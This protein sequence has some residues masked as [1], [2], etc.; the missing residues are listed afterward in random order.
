[1]ALMRLCLALVAAPLFVALFLHQ[2][3]GTALVDYDGGETGSRPVVGAKLNLISRKSDPFAPP[4][5]IEVAGPPGLAVG[6]EYPDFTRC[7]LSLVHPLSFLFFL[8]GV[9]FSENR[10]TGR[11]QASQIMRFVTASP[12]SEPPRRTTQG[13]TSNNQ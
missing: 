6:Y 11:L 9:I 1:M 10:N 7:Q 13:S 2:A 3:E 4:M 12:S 5:G 8:Y